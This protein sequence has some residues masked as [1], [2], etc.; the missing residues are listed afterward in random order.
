MGC[1]SVISQSPV[2]ISM[3][4]CPSESLFVSVCVHIPFATCVCL[5]LGHSLYLCL[6]VWFF[7]L[8]SGVHCP[9]VFIGVRSFVS[10]SS[11]FECTYTCP[12]FLPCLSPLTVM[13]NS[14]LLSIH[15]LFEWK[16]KFPILNFQ[17]RYSVF[18]IQFKFLRFPFT[19]DEISYVSYLAQSL[20]FNRY[21][22]IIMSFYPASLYVTA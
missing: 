20:I 11:F 17:N 16:K 18:Y 2:D 15:F 12:F 4:L 14:C 7:S 21:P 13:L 22:I 8:C 5:Y 1:F 9:S 19:Y 6:C 3:T 10:L